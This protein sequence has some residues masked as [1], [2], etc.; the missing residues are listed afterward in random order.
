VGG[1]VWIEGKYGQCISYT[2][3]EI[4]HK[5][6]WH[7]FKWKEDGWGTKWCSKP[8]QDV[9]QAYMEMVQWNSPVQLLYT[10]K[11]V[12]EKE[13]S[14][15]KRVI[16]FCLSKLKLSYAQWWKSYMIDLRPSHFFPWNWQELNDSSGFTSLNSGIR[17]SKCL[18]QELFL[19]F[20]NF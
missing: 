5:T 19:K 11:N 14:Q 15:Y 16:I 17:E 4:E 1:G 2:F 10:N 8:N 7:S 20:L 18:T 3:M 13:F 6:W 12:K 9:L